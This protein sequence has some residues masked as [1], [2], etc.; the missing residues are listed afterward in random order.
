MMRAFARP[1][2]STVPT[3]ALGGTYCNVRDGATHVS[4][5]L[6]LIFG[7]GNQRLR[8][9]MWGQEIFSETLQKEIALCPD[10]SEPSFSRLGWENG[11]VILFLS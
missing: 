11:G 9:G 1:A 8:V 4:F 5:F 6:R 7:W 2:P 10:S 3:R